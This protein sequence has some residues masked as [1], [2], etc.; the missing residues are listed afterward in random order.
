MMPGMD[1][2]RVLQALKSDPRTAD[3]PV[4]VC[5]IVD[6]RPLGYHL[7]ASDYAVKPVE[8]GA[9]VAKLNRLCAEG[10]GAGY[11][12]VVDD[13]HGIRELLANA[14]KHGGFEVRTASSG[15]TALKL[16][17][18]VTPR[19]VLCDLM[20]PGGMTGFEFIARLRAAP[21]TAHTP[22][23][24]ITG[25]DLTDEDRRLISGQIADVLRKGDLLISDIASRLGATL[26][27]LGVTPKDGQNSDR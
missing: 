20:M 23:V 13:E 11:V 21:A 12:L 4:I 19:A 24:V 6:N 3:I 26:T 18:H 25:K 15:E 7:G 9:L 27:A 1:G 14:L 16:A 5:S 10:D 17:A 2:W 8:P 22:V